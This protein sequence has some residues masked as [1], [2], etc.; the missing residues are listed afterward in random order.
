MDE[1]SQFISEKGIVSCLPYDEECLKG[2][3][4]FPCS[5]ECSHERQC[6]S[7]VYDPIVGWAQTL[8]RKCKTV[9]YTVD[10]ND[11]L[12]FIPSTKAQI[13]DNS[14]PF[15]S[16]DCNLAFVSESSTLVQSMR[17]RNIL[18]RIL[19]GGNRLLRHGR[20]IL[21]PL[22]IASVASADREILR[23]LPKLSPGLFF[24][25]KT[26]RAIYIDPN[27]LLHSIPKLLEEA[28]VQPYMEDVEGATAMLIGRGVPNSSFFASTDEN[29]IF[30]A[31]DSPQVLPTVETAVQNA[32]YRMV[33]IAVKDQLF[34]D[35][36][37][38]DLLDSR[39]LVHTLQS[40]DSRL[41]RCDVYGEVLQWK[42]DSDRSALEFVL[43]LHDMWSRVLAKQSLNVDPW[44]VG[45]GVQTVREGNKPHSASKYNKHRRLDEVVAIVGKKAPAAKRDHTKKKG[46]QGPGKDG[47]QKDDKPAAGVEGDDDDKDENESGDGSEDSAPEAKQENA[48]EEERGLDD[49]EVVEKVDENVETMTVEEVFGGE[50]KDKEVVA[51]D[52]KER[53]DSSSEMDDDIIPFNQEEYDGDGS[54]LLQRDYSAYDAWMGV[55]SATSKHYFVRIVPSSEVGV[56]SYEEL[57]SQQ[58][59]EE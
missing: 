20:W 12:E 14:V 25:P 59:L 47:N 30:D 16:G 37:F 34:G 9:L 17:G 4:V 21:I 45:D 56:I 40:D 13:Q 27:L 50:A 54:P 36:N 28:S 24:G 32:A 55:L 43:G 3:P 46:Q 41:F 58:Q 31:P 5:S 22:P 18:L 42:V 7:S 48:V 26:K 53:G 52:N 57:L 2:A 1:K 15:V 6:R 19:T 23:L 8:T 39:W 33:R 38:M 35:G 10:F 29:D 11:S 44:W 49:D 51:A